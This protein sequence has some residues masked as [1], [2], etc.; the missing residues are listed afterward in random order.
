MT[1][2]NARAAGQPHATPRWVKVLGLSAAA[3]VALV[4]L[5]MVTGVGGTHGPWRHMGVP[6]QGTSQQ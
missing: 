2:G 4:G 6:T 3:L 5:A 1:R